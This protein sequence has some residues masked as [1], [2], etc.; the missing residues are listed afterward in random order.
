MIADITSSDDIA[1]LVLGTIDT[2]GE[3]TAFTIYQRHAE[4]DDLFGLTLDLP[5]VHHA[6]WRLQDIGLID[7]VRTESSPAYYGRTINVRYYGV[8]ALGKLALKHRG[9][10]EE[11]EAA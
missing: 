4:Q 5:T 8:S 3:A 6:L 2:L 9:M 10:R 7:N 11:G 1:F